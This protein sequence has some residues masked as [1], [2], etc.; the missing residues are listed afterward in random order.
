MQNLFLFVSVTRE[1]LLEVAK[2]CR[3]RTVDGKLLYGNN[4]ELTSHKQNED[5]ND[6]LFQ[7]DKLAAENLTSLFSSADI[8]WMIWHEIMNVRS[9][10]KKILEI[11]NLKVT[12]FEGQSIGT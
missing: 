4:I 2:I 6:A 12:F 8:L 3:V 10:K 7:D 9:D 1:R 5:S 11:A